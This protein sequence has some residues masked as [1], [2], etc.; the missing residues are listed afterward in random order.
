MVDARTSNYATILCKVIST[1]FAF[2]T[3]ISVF[4]S[5]PIAK[6]HISRKDKALHIDINNNN[7]LLLVDTNNS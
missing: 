6:N 3:F 4:E 7:V 1:V 2:D 5:Q